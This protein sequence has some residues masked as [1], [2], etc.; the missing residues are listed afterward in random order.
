MIGI[1]KFI[2]NINFIVGAVLGGLVGA[3]LLPYIWP[4]KK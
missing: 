3:F 1:L 2:V 4:K